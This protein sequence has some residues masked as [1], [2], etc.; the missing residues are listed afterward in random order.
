MK[1]YELT[2]LK[3]ILFGAGKAAPGIQAFLNEPDAQGTLLGAWAAD[4]GSLNEVYLL[5]GFSSFEALIAE[6]QRV[7]LADNPFGCLEYL[8]NYHTDTYLPFDFVP[9]VQAGEY[10]AVYEIRTYHTKLNG[11]AP[12][13]EKW[14][15]AIPARTE[16]S[17]MNIAMYALD[18]SPRF[19]QIWPYVSA[20]ERAAI[21]AKSVADGVWPPQGGPAWLSPDMTSTLAIPLAFSPLK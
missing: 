2:T 4:I 16:L 20:N 15:A 6:R 9:P 13:I 3:T 18:G 1:Y 17:A 7:L 14:R 8:V 19:T 5:R 10:G 21:R 11:L 12:T